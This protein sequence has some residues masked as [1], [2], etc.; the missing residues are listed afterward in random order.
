M[1]LADVQR[2]KSKLLYHLGNVLGNDDM[3]VKMKLEILCCYN[4]NMCLQSRSYYL[5]LHNSAK[6]NQNTCAR[7]VLVND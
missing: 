7:H 6:P 5:F 1:A 2:G 4:D 3:S